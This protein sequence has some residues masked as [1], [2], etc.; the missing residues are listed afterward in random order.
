MHFSECWAPRRVLRE[1]ARK[2]PKTGRGR[3]GRRVL[4]SLVPMAK[5]DLRERTKVG[6]VFVFFSSA[7]QK[8]RFEKAEE[9]TAT[10]QLRKAC[11]CKVV[12]LLQGLETNTDPGCHVLFWV[13]T[14]EIRENQTPQDTKKHVF[15]SFAWACENASLAL[16]GIWQLTLDPREDWKILEASNRARSALPDSPV[17]VEPV[18]PGLIFYDAETPHPAYS[19]SS[20]A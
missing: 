6:D 20:S 17:L 8:I 4:P 7:T 1:A 10:L 15:R 5:R 18:S 16:V 12:S 9:E 3:G 13:Q 11:T 2:R 19:F 14:Q